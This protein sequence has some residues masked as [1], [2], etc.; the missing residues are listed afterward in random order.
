MCLPGQP[1][2]ATPA[3]VPATA[4]DAVAMAE[5][6]LAWLTDADT[7]ALTTTQQAECLRGLGRLES[8]HTAAR[9]TVLAAFRASDGYRDDGHGSA[10]TWLTWQTRIT[11]GAATGAMGWMRRLAA[12]P[13]VRG[14]LA[15]GQISPSWA[16][17][18][19][20]WTSKLPAE[21]RDDAD[22]IL[23]GAARG[24]ADLDDIDRLADEIRRKTAQPDTDHDDDGFDDRQVRLETTF[25]GAGKLDGDLTPACAAALGAVLDALGKPAGPEDLR[26]TWQRRHDAL[27]EACRRLIAA[28][29]LPDR[30]GQPT[31]IML[32]MDLDRLRGMPGAAEAEASWPGPAAPPGAE[33]DATIVP[34]VTG[35]VDPVVL[36]R[37]AA[38][39]VR[40]GWHPA[41]GTGQPGASQPGAGL[42]GLAGQATAAQATAAQATGRGEDTEEAQAARRELS[43]Q[44]ARRTVLAAATD[45][46]S[47]P[48]GLAAYL[49]TGTLGGAAAAISLPLDTG[50]ATDSI[51]AHLRR[52]VIARDRHCRFPGCRQRPAACHPHHIRPR[53]KGGRTS[54]TNMLLLCAF[55]HLIVV[56]RWGWEIALNPDGTVT[57]TSP[58]RTRVLRSHSPPTQAA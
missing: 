37:L 29:C 39:L 16:R 10:K 41:S 30:A 1:L 4:A 35:H 6:G 26:T 2:P 7:T 28:R 47:G 8:K 49:R 56:H 57:A 3:P 9:A 48:A 21:T 51:P 58:D 15:D 44:A 43:A 54:L 45:V 25:A 20:D 18:I 24:G 11:D 42:A 22:S 13:L 5:A 52:L 36:D 38:A 19:C 12:H 14:A 40:G 46:L 33:C 53:S 32:H 23:L 27:E 50:T 17:Q 34:V 55:H 31:Q